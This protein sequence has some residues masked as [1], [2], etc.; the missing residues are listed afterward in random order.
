VKK[1]PKSAQYPLVLSILKKLAPDACT[2]FKFH[3]TRKWRADFAIPSKMILIEIDGGAFSG[4]RHTRGM[5]FVNDIEK[6]NAAALL[7]YRVL[8]FIPDSKSKRKK[9]LPPVELK[10]MAWAVFEAIHCALP[11]KETDK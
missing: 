8:R 5:G 1:K 4:G 2:E 3:H 11:N 9:T 10:H 6:L 7:G